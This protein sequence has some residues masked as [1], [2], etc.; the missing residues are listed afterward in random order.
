MENRKFWGDERYTEQEIYD[1]L[2]RAKLGIELTIPLTI[3][4]K[5]ALFTKL[6]KKWCDENDP[7]FQERKKRK[8]EYDKQRKYA[9]K[10][11]IK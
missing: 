6:Y 8:K 1:N 4:R 3:L 11:I 5:Q 7:E 2:E 10:M 9:K